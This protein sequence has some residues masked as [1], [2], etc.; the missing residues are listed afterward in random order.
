MDDSFKVFI[1]FHSLY[2]T[3]RF[4]LGESSAKSSEVVP[5]HLGLHTY[6]WQNNRRTTVGAWYRD[7]VLLIVFS[8][9][10]YAGGPLAQGE[11]FQ[12][13]CDTEWK[14]FRA[15]QT[16]L[17]SCCKLFFYDKAFFINHSLAKACGHMAGEVHLCWLIF[18]VMEV[19]MFQFHDS[20]RSEQL[21]YQRSAIKPRSNH[22]IYFVAEPFIFWKLFWHQQIFHLT[23]KST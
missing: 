17:S 14:E 9:W 20:L 19:N 2:G 16:L 8:L 23:V 5:I 15:F 11:F 7:V 13:R 22:S 18:R 12:S 4:V 3:S 1:P 21:L 6:Q 10:K